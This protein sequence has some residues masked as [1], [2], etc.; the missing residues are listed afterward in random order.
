M[1]RD[2]GAKKCDGAA[3][4]LSENDSEIS[5]EGSPEGSRAP[6]IPRISAVLSVWRG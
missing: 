3:P 1:I 4:K 2:L 5:V 6:F